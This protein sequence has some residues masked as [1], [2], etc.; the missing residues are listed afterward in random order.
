MGSQGTGEALLRG[1]V[2]VYVFSDCFGILYYF[3]GCYKSQ[4]I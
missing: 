4:K 3:R 2:A 1:I